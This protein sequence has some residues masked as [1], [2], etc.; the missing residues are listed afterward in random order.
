[1]IAF[2]NTCIASAANQAR[3]ATRDLKLAEGEYS[4]QRLR[5]LADE[6]S[7]DYPRLVDF[8]K[9]LQQRPAS[10]KVKTITDAQ[11][12]ELCLSIAA[13]DPSAAG[14]GQTAMQVVEC[15][16][17]AREFKFVLI[18]TFYQ[19]GLVGVKL[20]PH[21]AESWVD[22]LGR[23]VSFAEINDETSVVVNPAYRRALGIDGP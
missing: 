5:A 19:V 4:R 23:S 22:E 15:T 3:L 17:P 2:F 14:L 12:G 6:W 1:M 21:E 11:I 20:V 18:R 8:A 13:D 16:L 10:F 9:I 7:A